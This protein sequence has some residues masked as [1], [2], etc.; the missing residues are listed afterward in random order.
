MV[1]QIKILLKWMIWG[2]PAFYETPPPYGHE[3]YKSLLKWAIGPWD[4]LYN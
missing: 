3:P 2:V 4:L 1:P